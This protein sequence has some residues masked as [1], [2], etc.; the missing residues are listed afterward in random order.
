[1]GKKKIYPAAARRSNNARGGGYKSTSSDEEEGEA[2]KPRRTT[3]K[4]ESK[5]ILRKRKESKSVSFNGVEDDRLRESIEANGKTIL[6]MSADGNCLFR[7]ISDQLYH[8]FGNGHD[9]VRAD[10]CDYLEGHEDFFKLFLVLDDDENKDEEDASDFAS[11][12]E[13]MRAEGEWGG[14]VEL[15]AAARLYRRN[16]VVF[17]ATLA[18]FTIEHG[19]ANKSPAGPDLLVSYHDNDHYNSVR[20]EKMSGKPPAPIKT[21]LKDR[22]A[23]STDFDD[24]AKD[25]EADSF[26]ANAGA[27]QMSEPQS[28]TPIE[29]NVPKTR[30]KKNSACPC[31]SGIKYKKCC[32]AKEKHALKLQKLRG[33]DNGDDNKSEGDDAEH[34]MNGDF[35]VLKI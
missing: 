31:G 9:E 23:I 3:N 27:E 2:E 13:K 29:S 12:V 4:T 22:Y 7:S 15:V 10:I 16:V 6:E 11:Y 5:R 26:V 24:E 28:E 14:N 1:M 30:V 35:R 20:D 17:S 18:A 8:D 25:D 32:W 34:E 33:N 19:H 21:Y